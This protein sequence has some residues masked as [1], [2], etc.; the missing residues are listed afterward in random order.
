MFSWQAIASSGTFYASLRPQVVPEEWPWVKKKIVSAWI[1]IIL[2]SERDHIPR[3]QTPG[4]GSRKI[5]VLHTKDFSTVEL[6]L[7][8]LYF[9]PKA[10]VAK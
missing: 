9:G 6:T 8:R 5:S 3:K 7:L 2:H 10:A 4:G 1:S